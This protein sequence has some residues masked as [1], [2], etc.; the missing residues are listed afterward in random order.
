MRPR[1]IWIAAFGLGALAALIAAL[2]GAL[3]FLF[4]LL[5]VPGLRPGTWLLAISGAL[6]GFG[7]AWLLLLARQAAS[8]GTLSSSDVW[9]LVGIVPLSLGLVLGIVAAITGRRSAS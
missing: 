9:L 1:W 4:I 7:V 6:I 2:I 5:A 3:G 8:G